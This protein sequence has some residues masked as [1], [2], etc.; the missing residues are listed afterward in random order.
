MADPK[1]VLMKEVSGS[2]RR[3]READVPDVLG[4][5]ATLGLAATPLGRNRSYEQFR[6][7]IARCC[8]EHLREE[9]R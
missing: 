2:G 7:D 3:Y 9:S 5:V 6:E 1:Q 4:Q 8:A